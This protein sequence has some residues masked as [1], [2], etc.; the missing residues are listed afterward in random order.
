MIDDHCIL[1]EP[2]CGAALA[3]IYAQ[4]IH[5]LQEEKKLQSDLKCVVAIVCGG[6]S[7]SLEELLKF[8]KDFNL[9]RRGIFDQKK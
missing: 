4:V 6:Y 1:V 9:W 5:R 3:G 2:S 7:I 8:K